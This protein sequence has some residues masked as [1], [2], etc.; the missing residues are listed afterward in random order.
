MRAARFVL[1]LLLCAGAQAARFE[2]L[3]TRIPM[4]DGAKLSAS[5]YKPAGR[6]RLP[7]LLVRTPYGKGIDLLP[8]YDMF[9][10]SGYAVVI[11]DV[12]GRGQSDGKFQPLEQ[13]VNDGND[14]LNWI[15]GQ[16]WSDGRIGMLG[17]SY[18]GIVQW[19]AA[20]SGNPHLK[21]IS[22][23]V[24][25]YDDY[26]DRF[27]SRGGGMKL[28]HRLSWMAE[29][30]RAWILREPTFG[31]YIWHLPL[32]T[33]DRAATGRT[34]DFWQ[35]GL[36]HPTYDSFWRAISSKESI[37]KVRAPVFLFGGWYDNFAESDLDA[38]VA[39]TRRQLPSRIVIGPWP[40]NMSQRF[41]TMDYGPQASAPV[42]RMQLGW[43]N[44]WVKG[45]KAQAEAPTVRI[46]V[47]GANKWRDEHE[48]PIART[49]FTPWYLAGRGRA[50]TVYGD[51]V[52]DSEPQRVDA[53][54]T[55][56]YDPGKPVPTMGGAV[57]C[58]PKIFPWGPMDQ[59]P[60]EGRKDVLVYTGE[61]LERDLEV[62]GRV[63]TLLYVSTTAP[64]TDFTAKLIDVYPDGR[65]INLCDG[66]LRLRYRQGLDR[67]ILA[68]PGEVYSVVIE[69]G[70][71]S[72]VFRT[73]HRVR[74]EVSSSNFPRFDRNPNTGLPVADERSLRTATQTI[75]HGR[76]HPSY[77]LLPVIP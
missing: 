75:Y 20:L 68:K 5:V 50:N 14:T 70:V 60:V 51:G 63:R 56:L 37:D 58:N 1:A 11:Q 9:I 3:N 27:Y 19:K 7:V 62:T 23:V 64:D 10:E 69:T 65:A 21:A 45:E 26:L 38:F 25:G 39:L 71:T 6:G 34:V 44:E 32:R 30:V 67:A 55:F 12:R 47:M 8:G 42:K 48:W 29:N 53:P 36:D 28:G 43:F 2:K 4:R 49:R 54:D 24:A 35:Q 73:G 46:F 77:L 76:Q 15:A 18:L 57:C 22:P 17:G 74:L 52:L 61:P 72:N 41:T 59:R 16:S 40:H 13:E 66:M 31:S 33:A